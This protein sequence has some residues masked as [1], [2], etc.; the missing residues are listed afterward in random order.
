MC[1]VMFG[2]E[3]I[4][5]VGTS[6]RKQLR[7]KCRSGD[8]KESLIALT[9]GKGSAS[10]LRTYSPRVMRTWEGRARATQW[11]AVT[12][13]HSL[14]REPPQREVPETHISQYNLFVCLWVRSERLF[15]EKMREEDREEGK[16]RK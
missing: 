14:T 9:P 3:G 4:V 7:R 13:Y 11:P 12:M 16:G 15:T 8:E 1:C 6:P 10:D 5:I 2:Q